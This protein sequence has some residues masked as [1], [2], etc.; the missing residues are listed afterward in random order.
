MLNIIA[1]LFAFGLMAVLGAT[2]TTGLGF[3][4]VDLIFPRNGTFEPTTLMPIVF[5]IQNPAAVNRTYPTLSYGLWSSD[6]PPSNRTHWT[7]LAVEKLPD[8]DSPVSFLLDGIAN[9][10]N[11]ENEWDF[12]WRLRWTNCSK[13]ADGTTF[14]KELGFVEEPDFAWRAYS[15]G[16]SIKFTTKSGGARVNLTS[17]TT[18][19]K[20][21]DMQ[22]FAFNVT[23]TMK[24]PSGSLKGRKCAV[25]QTPTPAPFPCKASVAPSAA[26]SISSTLTSRE[27]TA[28]TPV[29]SCPAKKGGAATNA[30]NSQM[31]W[32][33]AGL[34]LLLLS[35]SGQIYV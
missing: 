29:I 12:V 11:T 35:S 2:E 1:R 23:E 13:P 15:L 5:G 18:A 16:K 6:L 31:R 4:E 17:L 8:S 28:P 10:L 26:S 33:A 34:A 3:G 24:A 25:L 21:D 30:M 9:D 32:W 14:D 20:C 7:D 19:D 27:C 22:A